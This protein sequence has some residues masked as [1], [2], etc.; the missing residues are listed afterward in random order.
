MVEKYLWSDDYINGVIVEVSGIIIE[1]A[2]LSIL[3]PTVIYLYNL[4]KKRRDKAAGI[5]ILF[6]MYNFFLWQVSELFQFDKLR[7]EEYSKSDVDPCLFYWMKHLDAIPN[8]WS[9]SI[10]YGTVNSK[11]YC[12]E[13]YCQNNKQYP[14]DRAR[15]LEVL[16]AINHRMHYFDNLLS[17]GIDNYKIKQEIE[18]A[19][20][21]IN[22]A[23]EFLRVNATQTQ[24]IELIHNSVFHMLG[25]FYKYVDFYEKYFIIR[26]LSSDILKNQEFSRDEFMDKIKKLDNKHNR[27]SRTRGTWYELFYVIKNRKVL[28]KRMKEFEDEINKRKDKEPTM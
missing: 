8:S 19:K 24:M 22:S 15:E 28:R 5:G 20:V 21:F 9:N 16:E 7:P 25:V 17:F 23:S 14:I 4:R 11:M 10:H 2:L 1:I 27:R 13:H 26:D 6:D 12:I 18:A 3:V